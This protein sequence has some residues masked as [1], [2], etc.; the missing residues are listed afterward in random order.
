[1]H[2]KQRPLPGH[3]RAASVDKRAA[4][5]ARQLRAER[6]V[7]KALEDARSAGRP[8]PTPEAIANENGLPVG[9][10][11]WMLPRI[12]ARQLG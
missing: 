4:I 12:G 9:L 11:E 6:V 5:A 10:L 7:A 3:T 1:M 8:D 2:W